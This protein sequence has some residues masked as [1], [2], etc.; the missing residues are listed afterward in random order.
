MSGWN[1][2][3][4]WTTSELLHAFC[5]KPLYSYRSCSLI[6]CERITPRQLFTI[7]CL[8]REWYRT[9]IKYTGF[10]NNLCIAHLTGIGRT[11][12]KVVCFKIFTAMSTSLCVR[13]FLWIVIQRFIKL[14]V[15]NVYISRSTLRTRCVGLWFSCGNK[16]ICKTTDGT[17]LTYICM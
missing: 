5:T 2:R 3:Q 16:L 9:S 14:R 12:F 1:L 10:G 8:I 15:F 7:G 6:T 13:S 4:H 11:S 17:C